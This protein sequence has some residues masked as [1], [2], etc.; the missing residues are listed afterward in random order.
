MEKNIG[1]VINDQ[2]DGEAYWE[3]RSS[4]GMRKMRLESPKS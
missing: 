4:Y 2:I 1:A 3:I